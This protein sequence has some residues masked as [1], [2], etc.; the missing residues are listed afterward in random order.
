MRR[1][2]TLVNISSSESVEAKVKEIT[3]S[4]TTKADYYAELGKLITTSSKDEDNTTL[5]TLS[6]CCP[7]TP[8]SFKSKEAV[9]SYDKAGL[10]VE[11][12]KKE[13]ESNELDQ[14]KKKSSSSRERKGVL[15]RMPKLKPRYSS[16]KNGREE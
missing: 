7:S 16:N 12:Y 1:D 2:G 11:L 4:K 6:S 5:P 8:E 14:N 9:F 13:E 15:R 10:I 3:N